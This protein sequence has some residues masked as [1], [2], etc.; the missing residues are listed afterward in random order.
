VKEM[1]DR[2]DADTET[3][4]YD[5]GDCPYCGMTMYENPDPEIKYSNYSS[6]RNHDDD[7]VNLCYQCIKYMKMRGEIVDKRISEWHWIHEFVY[8]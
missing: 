8:K 2:W 5:K 6:V 1:T 7:I 3:W 4:D